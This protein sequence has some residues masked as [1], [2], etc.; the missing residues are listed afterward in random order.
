VY[1]A[2]AGRA[3]VAASH[4]N[5]SRQATASFHLGIDF[6]AGAM[7]LEE[8]SISQT[9]KLRGPPKIATVLA[10]LTPLELAVMW[11][12]NYKKEQST[13]PPFTEYPSQQNEDGE[14]NKELQLMS[15]SMVA[16]P[17]T[18]KDPVQFGL[19]LT[20]IMLFLIAFIARWCCRRSAMNSLRERTASKVMEPRPTTRNLMHANPLHR[21]LS[22][23]T[24]RC[25]NGQE[26]ASPCSEKG[27]ESLNKWL[28]GE[29]D[30]AVHEDSTSDNAMHEDSTSVAQPDVAAEP[31]LLQ[32]NNSASSNSCQA[33]DDAGHPKDGPPPFTVLVAQWRELRASLGKSDADGETDDVPPYN[34]L[35]ELWRAT[36]LMDD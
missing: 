1:L 2:L 4:Q 15:G 18:K 14:Q 16:S 27:K 32:A 25:V 36:Q 29:C 23:C 12:Y 26:V 20:C 9:H 3:N 19:T 35:I 5:L 21:S 6:G 10:K 31:I 7:F 28:L 24:E 22:V 34:C 33:D 13:S 17:P 30:N 11:V 8:H